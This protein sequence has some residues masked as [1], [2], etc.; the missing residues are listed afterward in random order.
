MDVVSALCGWGLQAFV[1]GCQGRG[2]GRGWAGAGWGEVRVGLKIGSY[3]T[4]GP[5]HKKAHARDFTGQL[6]ELVT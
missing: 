4:I 3:H 5:Y 1:T 6:Q 2:R